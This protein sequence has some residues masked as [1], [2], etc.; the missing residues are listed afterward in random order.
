MDI[1]VATKNAYKVDEIL[2]YLEGVEKIN[3]H[4]LKNQNIDVKVKEDGKSLRENAEKKAIE[5]SKRTDFFTLASDGG[6]EIPAL[7]E[8]WDFLKTERSV[9]E[10]K[11]NVE[12]SKKLL[13]MMEGL[14][15]EERKVIHHLALA[16]AKDGKLLWSNQKITENGYIAN[17]LPD[18]NIPEDKW[19]SHIWYYPEFGKVFN[20][21]DKLELKRVREQSKE[22]RESLQ[23]FLLTINFF[24]KL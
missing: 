15:G 5:I 4:L 1:L 19:L 7:G 18:E 20:K 16:L 2:F 13:T 24:S 14:E 11:N 23:I 22:L 9:G 21:L 12:K 8:D 6:V 17:E 3:I 10:E